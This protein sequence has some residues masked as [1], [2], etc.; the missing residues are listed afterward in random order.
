V[1]YIL[2]VTSCNR[3]DL[4]RRTLE[5]FSQMT[6]VVPVATHILEDS[7]AAR[8]E[9]LNEPEFNR[10]GPITFLRNGYTER[11]HGPSRGQILSADY[12]MEAVRYAYNG[13]HIEYVFWLEDD[14]RCMATGFIQQSLEILEAH[15]DLS[16]VDLKGITDYACSGHPVIRKQ[17][18]PLLL[19]TNWGGWGSFSFNPGLHR[20]HDYFKMGSYSK[21]C[22]GTKTGIEG[23]RAISLAY[24][25]A[26]YKMA[27]L[28]RQYFCHI[29]QERHVDNPTEY[30]T[31]LFET[32]H[33]DLPLRA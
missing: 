16:M 32:S 15:P 2:C 28:P 1:K 18:Y 7:T 30:N 29:G 25:K 20:R 21:L 6:D 17:G 3:H 19:E 31:E 33:S 5:S 26:G 14:W 4:L 8:P 23:E 9:W 27:A 13:E 11:R 12:L 10:L 22:L 24:C